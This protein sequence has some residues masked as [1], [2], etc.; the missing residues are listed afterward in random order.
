[1]H[2]PVLRCAANLTALADATPQTFVS[3]TLIS[4]RAECIVPM[5]LVRLVLCLLAAG[6]AGV[7]PLFHQNGAGSTWKPGLLFHCCRATSLHQRNISRVPAGLSRGA[8]PGHKNVDFPL[9]AFL[10]FRPLSLFLGSY[11]LSLA[12]LGII[13]SHLW[14]AETIS[15]AI[16]MSRS[17]KVSSRQIFINQNS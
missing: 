5:A 4:L 8:S 9:A 15:P 2:L 13:S 12:S 10:P 17:Q 1:M 7:L 3:N 14:R 16:R 6:M 11:S